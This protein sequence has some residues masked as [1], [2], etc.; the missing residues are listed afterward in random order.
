MDVASRVT[1]RRAGNVRKCAGQR[2]SSTGQEAG[3]EVTGDHS[4]AGRPAHGNG[5]PVTR[6]PGRP[7]AALTP[8]RV[9]M[10]VLYAA[11]CIAAAVAL[12]ASG[13]SY[14]TVNAVQ[15]I[16]SSHAIKSGPSIGA[17]N[18]L[19]MGLESRRYWNGKILPKRILRKLHAGNAQQ[20]AAGTGGNDTNTLILIH[21]FAGGRKA[22]GFSIP[23]D[24]WVHFAGTIGSQQVGKIDQAYGVSLYFREQQLTAN[25]PHISKDTL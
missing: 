16:G 15:S 23:R 10:R 13:L 20:V 3:P 8:R 14:R 22:V 18:I 24:D 9:G 5:R 4:P 2:Q 6:N 11:A 1:A 19:L 17:Q 21:I 7:V 25:D 12:V